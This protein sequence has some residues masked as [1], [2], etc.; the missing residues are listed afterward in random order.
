MVSLVPRQGALGGVN[1]ATLS[2]GVHGDARSFVVRAP[3]ARAYIESCCSECGLIVA[4]ERSKRGEEVEKVWPHCPGSAQS[5]ESHFI[6]AV[7]CNDGRIMV[8]ARS[9]SMSCSKLNP[10]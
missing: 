6:R 7:A 4:L 10:G 3:L 8:W 9:S 1:F 2:A 5:L